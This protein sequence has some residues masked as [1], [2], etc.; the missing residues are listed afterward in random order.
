[1]AAPVPLQQA[2]PIAHCRHI[3]YQR[4]T[5]YPRRRLKDVRLRENAK[6]MVPWLV[7]S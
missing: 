3:L 5:D 4:A 7:S 2:Q 6:Q 1:M